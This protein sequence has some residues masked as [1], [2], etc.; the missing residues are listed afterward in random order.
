MWI[1]CKSGMTSG[2][3]S[4]WVLC[5]WYF[6]ILARLV[7]LSH[8]VAV[9]LQDG[10]SSS[11]TAPNGPSQSALIQEALHT[12]RFEQWQLQVISIHGTGTP[13]GDPI[14]VGALG[15]SLATKQRES[16]SRTISL[17]SNKTCFGHTEG[18]AGRRPF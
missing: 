12:G 4:K 7:D 10:R 18:A 13:L 9:M 15:Q 1:R 11:L 17:Q 14:E 6:C 8:N 16:E 5:Y 2:N 3:F